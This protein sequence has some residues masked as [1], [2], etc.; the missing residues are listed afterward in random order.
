M[1]RTEP[2]SSQWQITVRLIDLAW[3]IVGLNVLQVLALAV[4]TAMVGRLAAAETALA[5]MGFAGQTVFLLMVAMIGLTVGSVA[6]IARAH[7][8]GDTER[9][10]HI[11]R[12]STQLTV[13][14]GIV[15]AGVGNLLAVPFLHLLG[16][17]AASMES[18]LAYLRPL[19]LGTAFNYLNILF[20][21]V[22]RG[23]G[24]TRLA[25]GVAVVM[26][27]LNVLFN[28]GL[29][30]G[31]YGLPQLGILGAAVGTVLA[32]LCAAALMIFLLYRDAVP[33]VRPAL[34]PQPIDRELVGD[35]YRIG[36]PAAL[37][38]VVLNAGLLTIIGL[39]SRV[40]EV[41]V[42]AHAIGLRIQALAFV[43]GMSISQ[44]TGALVGTALGASNVEEA[45]R[46]VRA[47]VVLC[48]GVMTSLGLTFVFLAGPLV[49]LFSVP[50]GTPLFDYAVIWMTLLG[51]AMPVVGVWIAWVGMLQGAGATRRSL[52][53]N[54]VTTVLCQIPLSYV[55]GFP[56]GLGVWGIWGAFP[57][58]F[59][60]KMVWGWV[61]YR[62][63][64][65]AR[66]GA[67]V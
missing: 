17:D 4:D 42:A 29:I 67:T 5:G 6:F 65:W 31:N 50:E 2:Q 20:A 23:V 38:M 18:A 57:L 13:L 3:P 58:A 33:G 19:L 22:L 34:S 7:G 21:A 27:G 51:F 56:L 30:L 32:Q 14:L 49:S 10:N 60:I 11:F 37:D 46:V 52:R 36:W 55:L 1:D 26:N 53:I 63:G 62:R 28:Y 15:V 45:R 59:A 8:A 54:V 25:F 40:D 12:Q 61:E 35:L 9:V 16:A 48:T 24:N 43:P 44:A 64:A 66:V 39:L 41:T 47:S